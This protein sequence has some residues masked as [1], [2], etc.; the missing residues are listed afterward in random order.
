[1]FLLT[2]TLTL[3]DDWIEKI[4]PIVRAV[5]KATGSSEIFQDGEDLKWAMYWDVKSF[6]VGRNLVK[7][8]K[9]ISEF[10][11]EVSIREK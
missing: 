11:V 7:R 5:G 1:M 9:S 2:V 8:V 6:K 4:D 3:D 10:G